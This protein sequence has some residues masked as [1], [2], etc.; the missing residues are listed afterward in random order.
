MAV[1]RFRLALDV[2]LNPNKNYFNEAFYKAVGMQTTTYNPT[3]DIL[4][5]KGYGENP[6]VNAIVNK[7][8]SKTTSVPYII[9]PI[10]DEKAYKQLQR[11]PIEPT[12]LQKKKIELLK[13][14]AYNGIEQPMPLDKPNPNQSWEEVLFL[15]KV[16][17]KV[18]GNVY[19]Y[20][21]SNSMGQPIALYIFSRYFSENYEACFYLFFEISFLKNIILFVT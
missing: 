7:M 9:K 11:F 10:D 1:N 3:L 16:Y 15:Y 12:Y 2:L 14:E 6:D 20:R 13:K 8:A 19:F 18:C 21:M 4:I 17:L 5:T